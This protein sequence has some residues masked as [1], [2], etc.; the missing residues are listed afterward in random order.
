MMR[1]AVQPGVWTVVGDRSYAHNSPHVQSI[2]IN[3]DESITLDESVEWLKRELTPLPY[4]I[5]LAGES[6]IIRSED[7][8]GD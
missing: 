3:D 8:S 1:L 7:L 6:M 4:D 5:I 2:V